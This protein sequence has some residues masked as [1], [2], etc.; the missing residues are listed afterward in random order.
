MRSTVPLS[1]EHLHF[2]SDLWKIQSTHSCLWSLQ[3]NTQLKCSLFV[4]PI[5]KNTE[6]LCQL[7]YWKL[8]CPS[9]SS[10]PPELSLVT[11]VKMI[12]L[13]SVIFRW[14]S[15]TINRVL[16]SSGAFTSRDGRPADGPEDGAGTIPSCSMLYAWSTISGVYL[17][18]SRA[19]GVFLAGRTNHTWPCS[20]ARVTRRRRAVHGKHGTLSGAAVCALCS[21]TTTISAAKKLWNFGIWW[22]SVCAKPWLWYV[23]L[24]LAL[25]KS[26]EYYT[27]KY[28]ILY[29]AWLVGF[30]CLGSLPEGRT[31]CIKMNPQTLTGSEWHQVKR[32]HREAIYCKCNILTSS[33]ERF[34][35]KGFP[36]Q[37]GYVCVLT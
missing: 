23:A 9:A 4:Q 34:W 11:A 26:L 35:L 6:I 20:C 28:I 8:A 24:C 37:G 17:A 3:S 25:W 10:S 1:G 7:L 12:G 31:N 30:S 29:C 5:L 15:W 36:C 27:L 33:S 14:Q 32:F 16:P 13:C 21:L 18:G 2:Q 19:V 22:A